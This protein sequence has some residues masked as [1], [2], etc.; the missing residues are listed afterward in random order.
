VNELTTLRQAPSQ[1]RAVTALPGGDFIVVW[2]SS[3]FSGDDGALVGGLRELGTG[4]GQLRGPRGLHVGPRGSIY[5][6]EYAD[7]CVQRFVCD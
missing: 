2:H 3:T 6:V 7:D 5:V 1:G 4:P